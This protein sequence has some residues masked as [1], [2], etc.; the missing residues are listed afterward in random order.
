MYN[1]VYYFFD[2]REIFSTIKRKPYTIVGN[3]KNNNNIYK[4]QSGSMVV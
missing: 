4:T 3:K 1:H 2:N